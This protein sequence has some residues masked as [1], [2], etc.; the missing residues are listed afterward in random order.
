MIQ[1]VVFIGPHGS[2][3]STLGKALA[4]KL[5]WQFDEEIGYR[6]RQ[7]ALALD[8]EA[9]AQ[10]HQPNFDIKV[11]QEEL[12]RDNLV[13]DFRVTETWHPG[14]FAFVESRSPELVSQFKPVVDKIISKHR[15]STLVQPL[16]ISL[17]TAI[18]RFHE[19]GTNKVQLAHW[20][21]RVGKRAI[22]IAHEWDLQVCS[23]I[24]T[25]IYSI[26]EALEIVLENIKQF[27]VL[28]TREEISNE[29]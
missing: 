3:K 15:R 20:F 21:M 17:E 13:T 12:K 10:K 9:Y 19:P 6:L 11:I 4:R 16:L 24:F 18:S 23:T 5:H 2:G 14:N 28:N 29:E 22:E 26:D 27:E 1:N 8:P 25:D 7:E